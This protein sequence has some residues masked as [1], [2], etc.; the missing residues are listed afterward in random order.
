MANKKVV[1]E[2]ELDAD[3]NVEAAKTVQEWLA[4]GTK[5]QFYVQDVSTKQVVSIDLNHHE[6]CQEQLIRNYKPIIEV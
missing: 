5:Y 4:D 1:F 2:I 6:S 3:S